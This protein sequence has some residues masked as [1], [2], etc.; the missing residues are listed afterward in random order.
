MMIASLVQQWRDTGPVLWVGAGAAAVI[1]IVLLGVLAASSEPRK[2]DAGSPTLDHAG[3]ESPAV[4]N[5]ITND[6]ELGHEAVPATLLDLAAR[7]F[8]TIDW[9]GE[10]T[11]VR[12]R[13]HGPEDRQLN[14]YEKLVLEHL[15]SLSKQ[16]ADGF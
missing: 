14:D 16:T 4:V 12:V 9:I 1:W 11:L 7:R 2:V 13:Q 8:V 5:L 15:R 10:R 3:P 6:W